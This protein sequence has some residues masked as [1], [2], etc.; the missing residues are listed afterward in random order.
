MLEPSSRP[1][2][3]AAAF[4]KYA[5]CA[6]QAARNRLAYPKDLAGRAIFLFLILFV[7]G[8]VW[9]KALGARGSF[10][11]FSRAQLIWYMAFT[12]GIGLSFPRLQG[13]VNEHVRTGDI[14]YR[15]NRP[16]SYLGGLLGEYLGETAFNLLATLGAAVLAA[17]VLAGGPPGAD[18]GSLAPLCLI[19]P[20]GALLSFFINAGLALTAFFVEDNGPF[21]WVYQKI[22]FVLG[23][24]FLPI[25]VYPRALRAA[26]GFLP[27]QLIYA[28]A[29]RL[30]VRFDR[31]MLVRTLTAQ[32]A[33]LVILIPLVWAIY[34]R[35]VRKLNVNGG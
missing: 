35:G 25:E 11:G 26:A 13:V 3:L 20:L 9:Q 14:A 15:L 16:L 21:F 29:A 33:W 23:G 1:G 12:E 18:L 4:A 17:R 10:G 22:H 34:H 7:Y 19:V 8:Q 30:A 2:R 31:A 6:V 27:F 5:A 32:A 24:L 28:A